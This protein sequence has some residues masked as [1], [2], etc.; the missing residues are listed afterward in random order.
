M[1]ILM[2]SGEAGL[3]LIDSDVLIW[4]MRGNPKARKVV[5]DLAPFPISSVS[6]MELIQGLRDKKEMKALREFVVNKKISILHISSEISQKAIFYMEQ[7]SLSHNLRMADALIAATA[8]IYG[9][10]LLTGNSRHYLH[11]KEIEVKKFRP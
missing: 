10:V 6:Y 11:I 4:Y 5:E 2:N 7:F 1:P 9:N 3:M 8:S